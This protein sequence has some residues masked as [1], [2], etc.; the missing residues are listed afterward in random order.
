[1]KASWFRT[2]QDDLLKALKK[3]EIPQ[4]RW[5]Q[6]ALDYDLSRRTQE[7]T[8]LAETLGDSISPILE[9][10]KGMQRGELRALVTQVERLSAEEMIERD[11]SDE[12]TMQVLGALKELLQVPSNRAHA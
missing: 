6:T 8:I 1:M 2:R 10:A 3:A 4:N 7:A 11:E 12:Y 9:H 5:T